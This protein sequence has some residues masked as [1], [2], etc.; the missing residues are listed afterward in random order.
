[1]Q[2]KTNAVPT[3]TAGYNFFKEVWFDPIM[4]YLASLNYT[5]NASCDFKT[6]TYIF[7]PSNPYRTQSIQMQAILAMVNLFP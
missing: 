2:Q 4:N 6:V 5:A 3:L 1:M 7:S